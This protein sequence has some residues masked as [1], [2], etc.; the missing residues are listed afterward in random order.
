MARRKGMTLKETILEVLSSPK[1]VEEIVKAV[2]NKKPKAKMRTI[3]AMLTRLT[4][5]GVI[6][7]SNSDKKYSKA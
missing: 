3:K 6:K 7:Y 1:T 5:E 4:K 2:K